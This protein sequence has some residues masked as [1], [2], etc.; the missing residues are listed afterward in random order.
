LQ[1]LFV[2]QA[3]EDRLAGPGIE[4][5]EALGLRHG[6]SQTWHLAELALNPAQQ[7][8]IGTRGTHGKPPL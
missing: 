6:Q 2:H 3:I 8:V 7:V 4:R 1:V 5:P